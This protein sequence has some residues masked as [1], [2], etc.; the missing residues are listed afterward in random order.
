MGIVRLYIPNELA[1]DALRYSYFYS[2]LFYTTS[3][4]L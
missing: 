4:D 3:F 2:R 1:L